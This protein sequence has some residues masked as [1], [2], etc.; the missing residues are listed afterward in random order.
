MGN[1]EKTVLIDKLRLE[2]D[3]PL[4]ELTGS[5]RISK[6]SYEYCRAKLRA[7]DRHAQLRADIR[8][9]FDG[10]G[11]TRGY[12]Y[13]HNEL[14][15]GGVVVSEKVVRRL[16][17]E[18][19]CRVAY[20]KRRRRYNSYKGEISDA[21]PN[22]VERDFRADAPNELWLTDITEFKLPSEEKAYLSP[23]IDCY[24]G[25]VVAWRIGRRPNA[26]LAN[27]SLEDACGTL[28]PG[29]PGL[30]LGQ[31]MPLQMARLDRHMRGKR[32]DPVHVE[33]GL[34]PGQLGMR[35]LL[36]PPEERVLLPSG[37]GWR[38]RGVV[39]GAAGRVHPLL[40][41]APQEAIARLDES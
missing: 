40:Q 31:G 32:P 9:I 16:M 34:Q 8:R 28:S 6:S 30:P 27:G 18:E 4:R 5:L 15:E 36:R 35:G 21:P 37:L 20:L 7:K 23:V 29:Q 17:A 38:H 14:R 2:S 26:A 11:G 33:E 22:L 41:R 39:H 10:A 13:V 12:R 1:M 24:D 19:G 3:R 25:L